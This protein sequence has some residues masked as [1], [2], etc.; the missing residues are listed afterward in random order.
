MRITNKLNLPSPIVEACRYDDYDAGE[1]DI[2]V[3]SLIGPS[4]QRQ[5][6]ARHADEIEMDAADMIFALTG[7]AL[8]E[9]LRR[10]DSTGI[11][12]KRLYAEVEGKKI[13][14]Q[15]DR[16]SLR[17][18]TLQDYKECSVWSV[19]NGNDSWEK[20]LNIYKYLLEVNG[21]D[22]V[23]GLQIV[24]FLRDHQK[25]KAK[26]DKDYPQF[27]VHVI[28][29]PVWSR[30]KTLEYI[31]ERIK[32]H[33]SDEATCTDEERWKRPTTYAVKKKGRKSALRVLDSE[34]EA[35]AWKRDKGGDFI[36]VREGSYPR[37][38]DYC[39]VSGFCPIYKES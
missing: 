13:G 23:K 35:V 4:L 8:H 19:I 14:G 27:R 10:A 31:R 21:Y 6:Q 33:F 7:K 28:D 25:S 38:A 24:A 9:V 3:T 16:V 2:S 22:A 26:F 11:T 39:S 5:L 20:Q 34:S 37:C 1:A 32:V 30:E 15:F 18:D 29:I 36:E 17:S 12:E